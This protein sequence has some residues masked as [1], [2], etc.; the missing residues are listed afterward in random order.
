MCIGI[1]AVRHYNLIALFVNCLAGSYVA[2]SGGAVSL[3][4]FL[5]SSLC[6]HYR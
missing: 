6:W 2:V 4:L 5:M 3:E 1:T